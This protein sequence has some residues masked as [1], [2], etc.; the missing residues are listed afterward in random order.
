MAVSGGPTRPRASPRP[1]DPGR[2][3]FPRG[4]AAPRLRSE[5]RLF[6]NASPKMAVL[7]YRL[8]RP[9]GPAPAENTSRKQLRYR[10]NAGEPGCRR[11]CGEAGGI[12]PLKSKK[13]G[14]RPAFPRVFDR[15][16]INTG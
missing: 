1:P 9:I 7:S 6:L 11:G 8:S 10:Q 16:A 5:S 3:D 2:D 4:S 15:D 14:A 12:S 13:A